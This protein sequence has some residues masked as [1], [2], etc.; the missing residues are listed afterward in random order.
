VPLRYAHRR[1][2]AKSCWHLDN[3]TSCTARTTDHKHGT[4]F[5]Q[6]HELT[7]T[8][9]HD[10]SVDV[11]RVIESMPKPTVCDDVC[12]RVL[13]HVERVRAG[14]D[15]ATPLA[16]LQAN[17]IMGGESGVHWVTVAY[18]IEPTSHG[19]QPDARCAPCLADGVEPMDCDT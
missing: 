18:S 14:Q 6:V 2:R 8:L 3:S 1:G 12:A 5:W 9:A 15:G 16:V 19:A 4:R 10:S 13:S 7:L 11:R 17:T